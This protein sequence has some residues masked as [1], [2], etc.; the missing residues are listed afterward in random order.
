M[1]EPTAPAAPDAGTVEAL[2]RVKAAESEWETKVGEARA[3]RDAAVRRWTDE[4]A[5]AVQAA[6]AGADEE[7]AQALQAARAAAEVEAD[8]IRADGETAAE[9]AGREDP[10]QLAQKREEILAAVLGDFQDA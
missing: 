3:H 9:A 4:S 6:V 8:R 2:K 7:R 10:K 1:S 5:A